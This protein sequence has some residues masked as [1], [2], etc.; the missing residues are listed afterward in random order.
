MKKK[1]LLILSVIPMLVLSSCNSKIINNVNK[2]TINMSTETAE[3][4]EKRGFEDKKALSEEGWPATKKALLERKNGYVPMPTTY[5]DQQGQTQSLIKNSDYTDKW[6]G[7]DWTSAFVPKTGSYDKV[8]FYIHGGA[9]AFAS[10]DVHTILCD[11]ICSLNSALVIAPNYGLAPEC[12]YKSAF[13]FLNRVY[14]NILNLNLPII[15]GGDSAGGG[16][17]TAYTQYL[18]NNNRRVPNKTL[19]IS[20]WLDV[21]LTNPDIVNYADK[22]RML[23]VYGLQE[24]GRWWSGDQPTSFADK[25]P[26]TDYRISPINGDFTNFPETLV[27]VSNCEIFYPDIN[28]FVSILDTKNIKTQVVELNGFGHAQV[29]NCNISEYATFLSIISDF[30]K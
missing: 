26:T 1:I 14:D 24:T 11:N 19:L 7:I 10:Y 4:F 16:L 25:I 3:Y 22:D 13:E 30:V 21:N 9:Y 15:I 2:I 17:A 29:V 27:F 23:H 18:R 12:N 8:V 28:K 5:I 20:P 6:N